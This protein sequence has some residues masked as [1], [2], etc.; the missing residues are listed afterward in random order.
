MKSADAKVREPSRIPCDLS[1]HG[2]VHPELAAPAQAQIYTNVNAFFYSQTGEHLHLQF[3]FDC[4]HRICPV[5]VH[6]LIKIRFFLIH[7]G[8]NKH[9]SG[10]SRPAADLFLTGRAH[11]KSIYQGNK[12]THQERICLDRVND[13]DLVPQM[14]S[15]HFYSTPQHI[16][17]KYICRC[18]DFS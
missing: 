1:Q 18:F 4:I 9:L 13:P 7:T 17:V 6:D 10:H 2:F 12:R 8:K 15:D 11:F 5:A 14:L 3:R 16:N